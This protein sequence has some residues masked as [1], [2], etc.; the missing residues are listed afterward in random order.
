MKPKPT[1][2][3]QPDDGSNQEEWLKLAPMVRAAMSG[4][5]PGH[6]EFLDEQIRLRIAKRKHA[7]R[8]SPSIRWMTVTGLALLLVSL[9]LT[10]T[11]WDS[12]SGDQNMSA[13]TKILEVDPHAPKISAYVIHPKNSGADVLW[14]DG[15]EF[16]PKEKTFQ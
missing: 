7:P 8:P 16:L 10:L 3:S 4:A 2:S 13:E 5:E 11:W 12:F 9:I 15:L 1:P 14:L 6:P